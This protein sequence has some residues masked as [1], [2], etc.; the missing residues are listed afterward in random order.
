M[1][2]FCSA[3]HGYPHLGAGESRCVVDAVSDH[4]N[5]AAKTARIGA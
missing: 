3:S 1:R 4:G 5:R 2:D